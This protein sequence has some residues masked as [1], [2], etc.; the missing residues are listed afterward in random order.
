MRFTA[1]FAAVF[2]ASAVY[3][4]AVPRS[5][6]DVAA[7]VKEQ[8]TFV[9]PLKDD[10]DNCPDLKVLCVKKGDDGDEVVGD[11]GAQSFCHRGGL[12]CTQCHKKKNEAEC[13]LKY[14]VQCATKCTTQGTPI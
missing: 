13:N 1:L 2:A 4:S 14:P 3:A 7:A 10:D 9:N 5:V 8:L 11:I 6:N 12:S